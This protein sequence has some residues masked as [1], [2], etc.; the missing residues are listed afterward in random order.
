MKER[1]LELLTEALPVV[2]FEADFLFGELD[3]LG[4][5]TIFVVLAKEYNVSFD[6]LDATPKNFRSLDS[7]VK[8]VEQKKANA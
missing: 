6:A 2:D 1:I 8:M 4:I 5:V 7:I 3:S